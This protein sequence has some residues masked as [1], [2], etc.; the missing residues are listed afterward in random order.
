MLLLVGYTL[1]DATHRIIYILFDRIY[2]CRT[3]HALKTHTQNCSP[4]T[5][6]R[7][8]RTELERR[9][10]GLIRGQCETVRCI[11]KPKYWKPL[12]VN[13][14]LLLLSATSSVGIA[15]MTTEMGG[16]GFRIFGMNERGGWSM[17]CGYS[18]C[19]VL[20]F[21]CIWRFGRI[22]FADF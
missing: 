2:F 18:F 8:A 1:D 12:A 21:F 4:F 11:S 16:H 17:G 3:S 20:I 9:S 15:T 22:F 14:S 5:I 13:C 10:C 19:F 7:R 6:N